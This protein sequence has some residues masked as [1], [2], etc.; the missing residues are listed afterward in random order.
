MK[1]R[2]LVADDEPDIRNLIAIYLQAEGFL[3]DQVSNGK[4]ALEA[5]KKNQ[6]E[7]GSPRYHDAGHGRHRNAPAHPSGIHHASHL[8]NC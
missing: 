8:P 7:F 3:V 6:Y 1:Q 2:I 5:L 4:E